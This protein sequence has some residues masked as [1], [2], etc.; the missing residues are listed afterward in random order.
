MNNN[1]VINVVITDTYLLQA[2]CVSAPLLFMFFC[3]DT[4]AHKP[5]PHALLPLA[6]RTD[7]AFLV[8]PDLSSLQSV[9]V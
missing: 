4:V 3:V 5:R 6:R 2:H 7:P 9:T 1:G 8:R